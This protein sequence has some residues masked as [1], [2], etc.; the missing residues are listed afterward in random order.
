MNRS[1]TCKL[2]METGLRD[3]VVTSHHFDTF[4]FSSPCDS[5]THTTSVFPGL[6]KLT[7]CALYLTQYNRNH[8]R[9]NT[10]NGS[11]SRL[12]HV[13]LL[14]AM[15]ASGVRVSAPGLKL[16]AQQIKRKIIAFTREH[17][18]SY[19]YTNKCL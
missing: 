5:T 2:F 9:V 6:H 16:L 14:Y 17:N 3:T 10:C 18:A 11:A 13:G 8:R 7:D 12:H 4:L 15:L 19:D 1:C